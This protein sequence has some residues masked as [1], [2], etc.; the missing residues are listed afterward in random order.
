MYFRKC[1]CKVTNICTNGYKR[2]IQHAYRLKLQTSYQSMTNTE[3]LVCIII[4][5]VF[6]GREMYSFTCS[7][8]A[9][10]KSTSPLLQRARVIL[11]GWRCLSFASTFGMFQ[12][13][14]SPWISPSE[15]RVKT[16]DKYKPSHIVETGLQKRTSLTIFR[17]VFPVWK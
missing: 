5:E 15:K 4:V 13:D 1:I 11:I 6:S 17:L 12:I 7:I 8:R 16:D 10:A 3:L 2:Y 9:L 14:M